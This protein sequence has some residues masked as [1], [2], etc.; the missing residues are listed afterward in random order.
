MTKPQ[1]L[2]VILFFSST[3]LFGFDFWIVARGNEDLPFHIKSDNPDDSSETYLYSMTGR[4]LH[5]IDRIDFDDANQEVSLLF[6]DGDY[7]TYR[8]INLKIKKYLVTDSNNQAFTLVKRRDGLSKQKWALYRFNSDYPIMFFKK[9]ELNEFANHFHAFLTTGEI[10]E[11]HLA[12]ENPIPSMLNIPGIE[13]CL[14][15]SLQ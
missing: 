7:I 12:E 14:G 13:G 6:S 3:K 9:V 5:L 8:K 2:L 4:R 10:A 11:Y 1:F 15:A